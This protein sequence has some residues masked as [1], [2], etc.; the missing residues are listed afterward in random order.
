[1]DIHSEPIEGL[2]YHLY[3]TALPYNIGGATVENSDGTFSVF[4]NTLR[5]EPEMHNAFLHEM[6]HIKRNH[7]RQS[8][9][10]EEE[11]ERETEELLKNFNQ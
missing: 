3:K 6:I 4:I 9:R 1:M 5:T 8:W 11:I 10:S 2:D 7:L